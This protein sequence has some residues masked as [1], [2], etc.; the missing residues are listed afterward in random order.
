MGRSFYNGSRTYGVTPSFPVCCCASAESSRTHSLSAGAAARRGSFPHN[1]STDCRFYSC[2][3]TEKRKRN[4]QLL[5]QVSV[6]ANKMCGLLSHGMSFCN[7]GERGG[8]SARGNITLLQNHDQIT[9]TLTHVNADLFYYNTVSV[10]NESENVSL[11]LRVN[12]NTF[13]VFGASLVNVSILGLGKCF[14]ETM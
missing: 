1:F 5:T 11:Q 4:I 8:E 7:C 12:V 6:F 10:Y 3:S 13:C 9:L 2:L 14:V